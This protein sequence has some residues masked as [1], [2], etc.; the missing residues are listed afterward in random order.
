MRSFRAPSTLRNF[1]LVHHEVLHLARQLA[2]D[3]GARDGDPDRA[4]L[5]EGGVAD[6]VGHIAFEQ[7]R[8]DRGV[9]RLIG[10]HVRVGRAVCPGRAAGVLLRGGQARIA[11]ARVASVG[12]VV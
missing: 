2:A 7:H 8:P 11:V 10:Q 9:A 5:R 6:D 1:G 3:G 12:W 4:Q